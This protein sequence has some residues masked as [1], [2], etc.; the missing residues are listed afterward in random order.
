MK[1]LSA[2]PACLF[3]LLLC[4]TTPVVAADEK[5]ETQQQAVKIIEEDI[6]DFHTRT[7][8]D[9][10]T[11][12][13]ALRQELTM[14][15][16]KDVESARFITAIKRWEEPGTVMHINVLTALVW[17]AA[18]F[19]EFQVDVL[20][21]DFPALVKWS[22]AIG[23]VYER[24]P[25][26]RVIVDPDPVFPLTMVFYEGGELRYIYG[27]GQKA[28]DYTPVRWEIKEI[29]SRPT[30]ISYHLSRRMAEDTEDTELIDYYSISE[31]GFKHLKTDERRIPLPK[32]PAG[33]K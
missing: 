14:L 8:P 15:A 33:G 11:D 27:Y 1:I 7:T 4:F 20:K 28:H 21:K 30:L 5:M 25:A 18:R 22:G 9:Y 26:P 2:R 16:S 24:S 29:D 32:K 31:E 3:L 19:C 10:Q 12:L 13:P 6:Q 23:I 17:H